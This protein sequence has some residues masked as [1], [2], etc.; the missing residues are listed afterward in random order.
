MFY[1]VFV[2]ILLL[3]S[4]ILYKLQVN[5]LVISAVSSVLQTKVAESSDK[6][7]GTASE[8]ASQ[9]AAKRDNERTEVTA[10]Q[11]TEESR[12]ADTTRPVVVVAAAATNEPVR[13][14]ETS[15]KPSDGKDVERK[16]GDVTG[17]GDST[18]VPPEPQ[19]VEEAKEGGK[20]GQRPRLLKKVKKTKKQ[21]QQQPV[22]EQAIP[23]PPP[24]MESAK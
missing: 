20:D 16:N 4:L 22:S 3:L 19:T 23:L 14:D 24:P 17:K 10:E 21:Q 18:I 8:S 12:T 5:C 13:A 9:S 7:A 6:E 15:E 2:Y 1:H 11:R